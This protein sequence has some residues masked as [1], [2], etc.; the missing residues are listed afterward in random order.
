[1]TDERRR[2]PT[3]SLDAT[4][5]LPLLPPFSRFTKG[6]VS[7][8]KTTKEMDFIKTAVKIER[9]SGR[10]QKRFIHIQWDI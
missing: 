6:A 5:P 3:D 10:R 1:V 2:S 4:R 9:K 8:R 7:K